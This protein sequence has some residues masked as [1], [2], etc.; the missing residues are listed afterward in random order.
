MRLA[1]EN[2]LV[3]YFGPAPTRKP[4]PAA[5]RSVEGNRAG[6]RRRPAAFR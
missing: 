3:G 5:R 1:K 4:I 6:S 2:A